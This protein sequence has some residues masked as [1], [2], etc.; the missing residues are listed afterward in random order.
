VIYE[1]FILYSSKTEER[2][3]TGRRTLIVHPAIIGE[4]WNSMTPRADGY[5]HYFVA[6]FLK[7]LWE[8][9]G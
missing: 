2:D 5:N 3:I 8:I 4:D 9:N 6:G 1:E 7:G